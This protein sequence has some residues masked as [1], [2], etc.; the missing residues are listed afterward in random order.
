[1]KLQDRQKSVDKHV[2]LV[3]LIDNDVADIVEYLAWASLNAIEQ[4]TSRAVGDA[5]S[6]LGK[7]DVK[8]HM[9]ADRDDTAIKSLFYHPSR[10]RSG[11]DTPWLGNPNV[12]VSASTGLDGVFEDNLRQLCCLTTAGSRCDDNCRVSLDKLQDAIALLVDSHFC[13]G[14]AGLEA[15]SGVGQIALQHFCMSDQLLVARRLLFVG[16]SFRFVIVMLWELIVIAFDLSIPRLNPLTAVFYR[17]GDE[18]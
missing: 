7:P 12:A 6:W 8:L 2:T 17:L 14:P 10:D 18:R 15:K 11:C 1:M 3:G 9:V 13:L 4:D 5:S 16:Q